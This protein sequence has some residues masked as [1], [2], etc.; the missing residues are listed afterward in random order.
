[1]R[2]RLRT[3]ALGGLAALALAAPAAHA[4]LTTPPLAI[5]GAVDPQ[6][7]APD[8]GALSVGA[9]DSGDVVAAWRDAGG[10]PTPVKL[11]LWRGGTAAP[12]VTSPGLGSDPDVAMAPDGHAIATWVGSDGR[13]RI[14]R[15]TPGGDWM[16]PAAIDA[17]TPGS[18]NSSRWLQ[19]AVAVRPD[20]TAVVA[21]IGCPDFG[22]SAEN[23]TYALDVGAD[24]SI[25]A[26]QD[27]GTTYSSM[28][29]SDPLSVHV[30]AGPGGQVA[31]TECHYDLSCEL[32]TRT[33]AAAP[34]SEWGVDGSNMYGNN[35]GGAVPV[36]T[37]AGKVVVTWRSDNPAPSTVR[38]SIG[39][40]ATAMTQ[41][42]DLSD[43]SVS[44]SAGEPF[45]FGSDVLALFQSALGGGGTQVLA[46]P[47]FAAG[48]YG[49]SAALDARSFA[50]DPHG[51]AWPDGS[52]V[53]AFASAPT[54]D[55]TPTLSLMQRSLGGTLTPID[56]APLPGRSVA[57]PRVAL[58]GSAA[59][60][61]GIVA[62]REAPS[63][64]GAATIV[65][66]RIDGV[67]PTLSLAVPTTGEVGA[68]LTLSA[69]A[70]DA[71]APVAV[72]WAFGDG[73]TAQGAAVRHAYAAAGTR[74]VTVTATDPA[75]NVATATASIHIAD[76]V[77]PAITGA[78]LTATRFRVARGAT[79]LVAARRRAPAGTTL[80]LTLSK[81]A[82]LRIAV[83]Q[84]RRGRRVHGRC[85]AGA[86]RGRRCTLRTTLGTLSRQ[87]G[88]GAA[89][90]PFS[91]RLGRR[92]LRPGR[93]ELRLVATDAA[94]NRSSART[95]RFTIVR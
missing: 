7:A 93:Y 65:L 30:A 77:R 66:R 64:G 43:S 74:T 71:S 24:G 1:M 55:A 68:P 36:I 82:K 60:P 75:G 35:N 29:C 78:R 44:S 90:I 47:I 76:H 17:P 13:L 3:G 49:A 87:L 73:D 28:G 11:L 34:W 92:A 46:R 85:R 41:L 21:A 88:S 40:T 2:G 58:A 27:S 83:V 31:L 4:G 45:I 5:D 37:P 56:V 51:A 53:I 80:R 16:A 95:L 39:T 48:T 25:G 52:G 94:G 10:A 12:Q 57:L 61:L 33:S 91:G 22:V 26:P 59:Q 32:A 86:H 20:G 84:A 15:R 62:T 18:P 19:S 79:A 81:P 6:F 23:I 9:A 8:G 14:A 42:F 63:G 70:S 72:S 67:P 89:A 69:A 50:G 54:A 38:A